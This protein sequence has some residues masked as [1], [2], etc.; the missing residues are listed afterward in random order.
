[1]QDKGKMLISAIFHDVN[2]EN[3]AALFYNTASPCVWHL[4]ARV[5]G[6]FEGFIS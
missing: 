1:M 2:G 6:S 5:L 3:I 4:L